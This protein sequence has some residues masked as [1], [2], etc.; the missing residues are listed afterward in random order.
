MA[1]TKTS[2][3]VKCRPTATTSRTKCEVFAIQT[4]YHNDRYLHQDGVSPSAVLVKTNEFLQTY[5]LDIKMRC[6]QKDDVADATVH[7]NN[8]III[9]LYRGIYREQYNST[10]AKVA[11]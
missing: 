1:V 10:I 4:L 2:V 5:E 9:Q 8:M 7:N 3:V 11:K 6:E